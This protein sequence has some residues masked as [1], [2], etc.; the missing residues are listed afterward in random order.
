MGGEYEFNN[1]K[2]VGFSIYTDNVIE[3]RV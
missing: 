1:L 3:N 2:A